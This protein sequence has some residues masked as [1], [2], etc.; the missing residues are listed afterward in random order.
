M[1]RHGPKASSPCPRDGA[2][3]GT[4]KKIICAIDMVRAI[5]R[6]DEP[7]RTIA[8]AS[9]RVEADISPCS[10]RAPSSAGKVAELAAKMLAATKPARLAIST[11][12]R[13]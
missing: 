13:P 4:R 9:T 10:M 12:R 2:R 3:I 6:P 7:S 11:G 1:K 5:C 8:T